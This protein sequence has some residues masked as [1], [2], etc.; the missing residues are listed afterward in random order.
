VDGSRP[1]A[2]VVRVHGLA[3]GEL[4]DGRPQVPNSLRAEYDR[5]LVITDVQ[6]HDR[7]PAPKGRGYVV[8]VA[9]ARNGVG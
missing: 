8:N 5:I 7:V 1:A 3:G 9:S 2:Y 4:R 6:S